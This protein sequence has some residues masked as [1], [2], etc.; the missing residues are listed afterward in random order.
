MDSLNPEHHQD[1]AAQYFDSD[2]DVIVDIPVTS[3][4]EDEAL[5]M[6]R[7]NC[8]LWINQPD[9]WMSFVTETSSKA[10][11]KDIKKKLQTIHR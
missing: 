5:A 3:D 2:D 7:K 10:K 9:N 4:S 1:G 8:T 11:H 6:E